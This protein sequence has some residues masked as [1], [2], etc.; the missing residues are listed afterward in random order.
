M[1]AMHPQRPSSKS[2]NGGRKSDPFLSL[3]WSIG[4]RLASCFPFLFGLPWPRITL[5]VI[6]S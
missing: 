4:F 2:S 3:F 6:V 5:L 1:R